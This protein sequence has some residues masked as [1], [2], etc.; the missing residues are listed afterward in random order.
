MF[1]TSRCIFESCGGP[2]P[3]AAVAADGPRQGISGRRGD[4]RRREWRG[5]RGAASTAAAAIQVAFTLSVPAV[6]GDT[7]RIALP[8]FSGDS[9]KNCSYVDGTDAGRGVFWYW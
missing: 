4:A 5:R 8:G 3:A 9:S 2:G 7:L 6:V 1:S